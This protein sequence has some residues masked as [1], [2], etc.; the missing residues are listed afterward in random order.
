MA[1]SRKPFGTGHMYMYTC[2]LRM[3]DTMTS[4]NIDLSSWNIRYS[5]GG[6]HNENTA[7]CI[8]ASPSV[9][10]DACLL[11]ICLATVVYFSF[12]VPALRR[13][14]TILWYKKACISQ[15]KN[16]YLWRVKKKSVWINVCW[17]RVLSTVLLAAYITASRMWYGL[18]LQTVYAM[19]SPEDMK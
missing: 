8:V 15:T 6:Y 3:T 16:W 7:S 11:H 1:L 4:Q 17:I 9:A 19:K 2:L 5:L 10:E 13:H 14:I 18:F 12:T